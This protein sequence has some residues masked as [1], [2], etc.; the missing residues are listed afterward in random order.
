M[1]FV[2]LCTE[3]ALQTLQSELREAE[4]DA[5][6]WRCAWEQVSAEVKAA[7]A[8]QQES[9]EA[10]RQEVAQMAASIESYRSAQAEEVKHSTAMARRAEATAK[11]SDIACRKA[12]S[13]SADLAR[14]MQVR[15]NSFVSKRK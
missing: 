9:D 11:S 10:W 6:K 3:L 4:E 15:V 7:Q 14:E 1:L 13:R 12:D 8:Q 2:S 5:A